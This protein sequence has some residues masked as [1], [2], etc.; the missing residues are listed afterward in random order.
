MK[1]SRSKR[2]QSARQ[3]EVVKGTRRMQ[4]EREPV[5]EDTEVCREEIGRP[6]GGQTDEEWNH[7]NAGS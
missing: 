2:R 6:A 5:P 1:C 4:K 7:G 3:L